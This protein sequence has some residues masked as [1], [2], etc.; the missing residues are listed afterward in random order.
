MNETNQSLIP[1]STSSS[2]SSSKSLRSLACCSSLFF[3]CH[4][5]NRNT[6]KPATAATPS[7]TISTF[8]ATEE[9]LALLLP[10]LAETEAKNKGIVR[11]RRNCRDRD[12]FMF[13]ESLKKKLGRE[14]RDFKER[15]SGCLCLL[16][17]TTWLQSPNTPTPR[18]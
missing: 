8:S 5:L 16:I 2:S 17:L 9:P 1:S 4:I 10:S 6:P 11:N 18:R 3:L 7:A 15:E 12:P 13:F 14:W